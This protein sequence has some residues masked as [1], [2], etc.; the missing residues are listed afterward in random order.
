MW[1]GK[2]VAVWIL[3]AFARGLLR[4]ARRGCSGVG[5]RRCFAGD[6]FMPQELCRG[7]HAHAIYAKQCHSLQPP[8]PKN[9]DIKDH[10]VNSSMVSSMYKSRDLLFPSR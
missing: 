4:I 10:A 8:P 5:C 9:K 3:F 7:L 6:V 2:I 1:E